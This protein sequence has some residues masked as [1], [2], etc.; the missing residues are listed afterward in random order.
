MTVGTADVRRCCGIGSD[1][2]SD[3][4]IV[5]L[6]EEAE[7]ETEK[8]L[9]ASI[10]PKTS[11]ESHDGTELGAAG[12]ILY[13]NHLPILQV[14]EIKVDGTT[15][16]PE[17]VNVFSGSG[18][19]VLSDDAEETEWDDTETKNNVIKYSHG[20]IEETLTTTETTEGITSPTENYS[21]KA[22]DITGLNQNDYVRIEGMDGNSEITQVDN[23][24]SNGSFQADIYLTH[25]TS[26]I[27]TLMTTP[28]IV[29]R[30]I[31]LTASLMLVSREVGQSYDDITGYSVDGLQVQLGEPYTQWRETAVQL[32]KEFDDIKKHYRK[33][34]TV[35]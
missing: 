20:L 28:K 26:S 18:K 4:D 30:L 1:E 19:M 16:S 31:A 13:L 8:F 3:S 34:V 15:V 33:Q 10:N 12:K 2:I 5:L 17:Y 14:K 24:P 32:R 35:R 23:S 25:E 11:I 22:S 6:I 21:V 7:R 27:I 9:N 29:D